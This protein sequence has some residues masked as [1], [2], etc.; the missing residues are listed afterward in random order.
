MKAFNLALSLLLVLML[1][2]QLL[3][4]KGGKGPS[5]KAFESASEKASFKREEGKSGK[6]GK[7]KKEKSDHMHDGEYHEHG[8]KDDGKSVK[9][10]QP[11]ENENTGRKH[12]DEHRDPEERGDAEDIRKRRHTE[13]EQEQRESNSERVESTGT[14]GES[15]EENKSETGFRQRIFGKD[16]EK[17]TTGEN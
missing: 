4:E 5:D 7:E 12:N 14:T 17:R 9:E 8:D 1:P 6:G 15:T 13:Q 11:V 10:L 2:G 16:R 3:A